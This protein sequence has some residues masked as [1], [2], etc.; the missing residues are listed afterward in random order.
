MSLALTTVSLASVFTSGAPGAVVFI[1][2]A[3]ITTCIYFVNW[4]ILWHAIIWDGGGDRY[5]YCTS[6]FE[7]KIYTV[8]VRSRKIKSIST[9][10]IRT[11]RY[12]ST[13]FEHSTS[14]RCYELCGLFWIFG[15]DQIIVIGP[16]KLA[17]RLLPTFYSVRY[18][19]SYLWLQASTVNS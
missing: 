13:L 4:K 12:R 1:G 10:S 15:F 8:M 17:F 18:R 14:P 5:D 16:P 6:M 2:S 19:I 9:Y 7:L 11:V 3:I